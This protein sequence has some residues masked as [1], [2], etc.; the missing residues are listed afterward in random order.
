M[1]SEPLFEVRARMLNMRFQSFDEREV[2]HNHL[3]NNGVLGNKKALFYILR[4][5]C[6]LNGLNVFSIVPKT[7]HVQLGL[8]DNQFNL[9][10]EAFKKKEGSVSTACNVWIV[11]PGEDTNRGSGIMCC[12]TIEAVKKI[13]GG[14]T[15]IE[16]SRTYILQEYITNPLLYNSRKFD[17]RVYMLLTMNNGVIKG[18][19]Y[20]EGYV[21]T[22]SY[23]YDLRQVG[24]PMIHLT[25][26]AIQKNCPDYGRY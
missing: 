6:D 26:D 15:P 3:P 16:G 14:C 11:K 22:S 17:I 25:N 20:R 7:Y 12:N 8:N 21:R 2:Q 4:E 23:K 10:V 9:F 19:W 18:Y 1:K 24:D 5:Y 13:V